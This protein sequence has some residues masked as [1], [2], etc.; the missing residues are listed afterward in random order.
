MSIGET[1]NEPAR[2]PCR[3][4]DTGDEPR[5][6]VLGSCALLCVLDR[7][8][9]STQFDIIST[10]HGSPSLPPSARHAISAAFAAVPTGLNEG[11]CTRA[12]NFGSFAQRQPKKPALQRWFATPCVD[13]SRISVSPEKMLGRFIG[14]TSAMAAITRTDSTSAQAAMTMTMAMLISRYNRC[15]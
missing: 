13:Q 6:S 10:C 1:T 11:G 4:V 2:P 9:R 5:D 14:P 3:L 7:F 12:A 8:V 15:R